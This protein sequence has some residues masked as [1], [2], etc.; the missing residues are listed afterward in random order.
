[1]NFMYL[2][3]YLAIVLSISHMCTPNNINKDIITESITYTYN[4]STFI[5]K[6]HKYVFI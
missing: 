6:V 5:N 3:K 2:I 1:M 4:K